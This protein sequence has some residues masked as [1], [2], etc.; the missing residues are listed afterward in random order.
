M[1]SLSYVYLVQLSTGEALSN[2]GSVD[3]GLVIEIGLL[4][5]L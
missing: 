5:Q 4:V 3:V 1:T 2:R